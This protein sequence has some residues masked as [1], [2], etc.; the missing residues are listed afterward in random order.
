MGQHRHRFKGYILLAATLSLLLLVCVLAACA[1]VSHPTPHT[2][3]FVAGEGLTIPD[4]VA[5]AGE[6]I[7]PPS[8]PER[9]GFS[10]G[11]W[12]L[13]EKGEGERQLLPNVMPKED[14]TYYAKWDTLPPPPARPDFSDI[15]GK[16]FPDILGSGATLALQEDGRAV[17]TPERGEILAGRYTPSDEEGNFLLTVDEGLTLPFALTLKE[18]ALCFLLG[19]GSYTYGGEYILAGETLL[20]YLG[21]GES[22]RVPDGV[23]VI[24][25]NAFLFDGAKNLTSVDFNEA[26]RVE[27]RAFC[28]VTKLQAV[29]G[30]LEHVGKSA[31]E[32][33]KTLERVDLPHLKLISERAFFGCDALASV[34]LA[35]VERIESAAFSRFAE[36]QPLTL[37]LTQAPSLHLSVAEDAFAAIGEENVSVFV[38]GS[39][40]LV[41]DVDALNAAIQAF[42]DAYLPMPIAIQTEKEDTMSE[43]AFYDFLEGALYLFENFEVTK[44]VYINYG[45]EKETV[46]SYYLAEGVAT[47]YAL[48]GEGKYLSF[49]AYTKDSPRL[50]LGEREALALGS[51]ERPALLLTEDSAGKTLELSYYV[52]LS[53]TW[54]INL[55]KYVT[56]VKYDG[57]EGTNVNFSYSGELTFTAANRAYRGSIVEGV[58]EIEYLGMEYAIEDTSDPDMYYRA[59]V[60]VDAEGNFSVLKTEYNVAPAAGGSYKSTIFGTKVEGENTWTYEESGYLLQF[61]FTLDGDGVPSL[62]GEILG[63]V[64]SVY[65]FSISYVATVKVEAGKIAGLVAFREHY[66][67]VPEEDITAEIAEDGLSMSIQTPLGKYS[68]TL[69]EEGG[70]AS[71][72]F[73]VQEFTQNTISDEHYEYNADVRFKAVGEEKVMIGIAHFYQGTNHE[74]QIR[75]Q[76]LN[77]DNSVT[78]ETEDGKKYQISMGKTQYGYECIV[79]REIG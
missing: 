66:I 24:G 49:G 1:F 15:A 69:S 60:R 79:V 31:F 23:Q 71:L 48:G 35:A 57:V 4:I 2:L 16:A 3:K 62:K 41:K 56:G 12:Y 10:F 50:V 9:E 67:T 54:G 8:D 61:A 19:D 37:D 22:F 47:V 6:D 45:W 72:S 26:V 55:N 25:G 40:I 59:T 18:D 34:K 65:A 36:G 51:E 46:A 64:V 27:P 44:N 29:E 70:K 52:T 42:G 7:T 28:G 14:R 53:R 78:V 20:Y 43:V 32:G 5:E 68:V 75:S 21:T 77:E 13:D 58:F 11:G 30:N 39:E 74:L 63:N 76:T 33:L 38:E 17:Y 73:S